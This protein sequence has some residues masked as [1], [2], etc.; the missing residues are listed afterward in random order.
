MKRK[1]F[2]GDDGLSVTAV[3]D[4]KPDT[5]DTLFVYATRGGLFESEFS[6]REARK[7]V[8]AWGELLGV[9]EAGAGNAAL[10]GEGR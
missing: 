8:A 9:V 2:R 7:L 5:T 3:V 6:R 10:T 4:R 1:E